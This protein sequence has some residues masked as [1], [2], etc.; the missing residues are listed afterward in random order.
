MA[1][2]R[3]HEDDADKGRATE[4]LKVPRKRRFLNDILGERDY[5]FC[6]NDARE[7][8][9]P[10]LGR[11]AD[12]LSF[13]G[14]S[15]AAWVDLVSVAC[16]VAP[17]G[18]R[19][20]TDPNPYSLA[21]LYTTATGQ[22]LAPQ[23]SAYRRARAVGHVL[24]WLVRSANVGG[25]WEAAWYHFLDAFHQSPDSRLAAD[26]DAAD[27][28]AADADAA[29]P[30][31]ETDLDEGAGDPMRIDMRR[32]V[33]DVVDALRAAVARAR[34]RRHDAAGS[35]GRRRR[36][37]PS[38]RKRAHDADTE[39]PAPEPRPPVAARSHAPRAARGVDPRLAILDH[40]SAAHR[41]DGPPRPPWRAV[42]AAGRP[43]FAS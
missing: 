14:F 13:K 10:L 6:A 25:D 4:L 41:S 22:G 32:A 3:H 34:R 35:A 37:R 7:F 30:D 23:C 18:E 9:A 42:G 24:T 31:A 43:H 8:V 21:A 12:E 28:N 36:R 2:T 29:D 40:A 27:A 11:L 15:T 5:V 38:R 33:A 39:Q 19:R 26:V 16:L 17:A 20:S 1:R